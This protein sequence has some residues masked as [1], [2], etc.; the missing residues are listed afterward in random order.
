MAEIIP[1]KKKAIIAYLSFVGFL[2][3]ATMNSDPKDEFATWHI[4]NMFGI[5]L[6]WI[7]S[8]AVQFNIDLLTGDI[9]NIISVLMLAYSLIMAI[10]GKKKAIPFL[11]K[12][13]QEWFTFLD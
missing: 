12:K 11:S 6:I 8:M 1:G 4:K 10:L 2:I 13:F 9:L 5:L 7:V 3:A